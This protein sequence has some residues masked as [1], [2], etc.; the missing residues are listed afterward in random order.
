M[1]HFHSFVQRIHGR[2][3]LRPVQKVRRT[4]LPRDIHFDLLRASA[5][6]VDCDVLKH[7]PAD[8]REQKGNQT[9]THP[10]HEELA[11]ARSNHWGSLIDLLP[12]QRHHH[13]LHA[14]HR[15]RQKQETE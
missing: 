12:N 5:Q 15:H 7:V 2:A 8:L 11:R 13:P 6:L 4:D 14:H 1:G 9:A 3:G 10:R